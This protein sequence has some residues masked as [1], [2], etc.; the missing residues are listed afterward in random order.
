MN[1]H[2]TFLLSTVGHD[3][4]PDTHQDRR[5]RQCKIHTQKYSREFERSA[6]PTREKAKTRSANGPIPQVSVYKPPPE[7]RDAFLLTH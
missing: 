3:P 4:I 5:H 7:N 6:A 1:Q 2:S